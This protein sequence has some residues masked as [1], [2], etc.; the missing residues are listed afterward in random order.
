MVGV[1]AT[2]FAMAWLPAVASAQPP[3]ISIIS[4]QPDSNG[5]PY[6]LTVT[7]DDGNG[8]Q[9]S[10]MTAH[11]FDSGNN[12]VADPVMQYSSGPAGNQI[13]TP[14]TPIPQ[15]ALPPGTYTVTVD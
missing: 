3:N 6:D 11:V 9:I 14:V 7:A 12:D 8:L 2:L 10:A 4:A 5:D 13:W 1:T 15:S